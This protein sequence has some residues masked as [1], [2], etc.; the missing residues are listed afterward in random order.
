MDG[1]PLPR[2]YWSVAAIALGIGM[3]VL[4]GAVANVALPTIAHEVGATPA[5]STWVI[6]AYQLA[7]VVTLLPFAAAGERFGYRR[8]YIAGLA[9]FTV[10]SLACAL[11]HRLTALVLA[12]VAQGIGASG[13]MSMNGALVRFTYPRAALGR[14]VGF[15]ALVVSLAAAVGPTVASGILSVGS[16]EW[17]FA[18]NVPLG[19]V[20]LALAVRALPEAETSDRPIDALNVGLNA[21]MFGLFFIGVDGFAQG[22]GK[23]GGGEVPLAA[24]EVG[25]ALAAGVWLFRREGQAAGPLIPVD[26]LKIPVFAQSVATSICAFTAYML[27]YIALPFLFETALHRDAVQTGLLMTPW[28]MALGVAAPLAGR[29][30]DRFPAAILGAVGLAVLSLGLTLLAVLPPQPS[31]ADIVWRMALCGF[32]FGFFQSPNNRTLLSTAP[33]DR[34]GAAGGMLAIARLIGFTVGTT[35]VALVFRVDSAHAETAALVIGAGFA[36]VAA[37]ASLT[38][39]RGGGA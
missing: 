28:P 20:N 27:A 10:A 39:L 37:A 25:V 19:L 21:L 35:L 5:A 22:G 7:T 2:R 32:G 14:G 24:L 26:L 15:N 4:D 18:I 3:A 34:S 12:R 30:S 36:I 23:N 1:L 17:L 33:R 8:V 16:W 13:L 38:R 29:L 11:S 6:N 9:L 31:T